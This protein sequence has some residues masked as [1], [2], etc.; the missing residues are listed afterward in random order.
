MF[1]N[2][3]YISN[4]FNLL[5][6]IP[7]LG[8]GNHGS[9]SGGADANFNQVRQS[10]ISVAGLFHFKIH[11]KG[12]I[13]MNR[14]QRREAKKLNRQ[15]N[16][17]N[18]STPTTPTPEPVT[19]P[20]KTIS[21]AQLAANQKNA[22][23]STGPK[24]EAG[25]K[26]SSHNAVKTALTGQTILL[27]T[28]D[29]AAYQDLGRHFVER[30][31]PV[32]FEEECLVQSLIDSEWRL[33]R[34]PAQEASICAVYRHQLAD[35]VSAELLE[36]EVFLK[37]ERNLKNLRLHES[38]LRRYRQNDLRALHALQTSRREKEAAQKKLQQMK[39]KQQLAPEPAMPETTDGFVFTTPEPPLEMAA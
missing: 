35:T 21:D 1:F 26:V 31:K 24:T 3:F 15:P 16:P 9:E 14:T 23:S 34:I 37:S 36:G 11:E 38:R 7:A 13:Y 19:A 4:P 6:A 25:K 17:V 5:R 30:H 28:D 10:V 29:V 20:A 27:P 12:T 22:S 8:S 2:Y 18:D 33:L 39:D 32:G